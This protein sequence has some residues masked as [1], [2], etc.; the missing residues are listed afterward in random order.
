MLTSPANPGKARKAEY[1]LGWVMDFRRLFSLALLVVFAFTAVP[2][3][4]AQQCAPHRD[5]ITLNFK[6][7][8]PAAGYNNRLSIQG[9]R[10]MFG[11]HTE[12]VLGPHERA[13]G[14]T[15]AES[16]FGAEAKSDAT[17]ARGG[18]C[19]YLNSLD[20][21][22]GW[23]R[24]QVFVA[25]EFQPSTCEYRSVLDHENQHVSINNGALKD[26]APRFRAEV[27]KILCAQQPVFVAG[28]PERGMDIAL[29]SVDRGMSELLAQFQDLMA[30]RNAPLDS[31][32]NYAATG[33]LCQNWTGT[34]AP[35][36]R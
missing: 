23:K 14:I 25:S 19:V 16:T 31:A 2:A 33:K 35:A 26:F 9:I 7:L 15:Y 34:G 1:T 36:K 28:N 11:S 30:A 3:R 20:V 12:A 24:M 17:S 22:F 13:L 27:E 6:T 32:H 29:E 4:A 8:S 5:A 10:N 18:Y 21:Q